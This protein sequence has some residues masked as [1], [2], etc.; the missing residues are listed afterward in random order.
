MAVKKDLIINTIQC[1]TLAETTSFWNEIA[2]KAEGEY[3]AILQDGGTV[4]VSTP[5]D[6]EIGKVNAA[7][8][9]TV[10]GYGDR[11]MQNVVQEKLMRAAEAPAE[12]LAERADF[13]QKTKS[14]PSASAK[15]VSG[16]ADLTE[17]AADGTLKYDKLERANLPE[18]LKSLSPEQQKAEV[19]KNVAERKRLNA[20]METLVKKRTDFLKG[21]KARKATTDK[22]DGFDGQVKAMIK[23]QAAGKGIRY[24]T[25]D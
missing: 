14:V 1:G 9:K 17:L 24:S 21:E 16:I 15:V 5:F 12:A 25:D 22:G 7:L 23:K 20:E 3:A 10:L 6:A 18:P 11:M 2:D 8:S 19:E 13:L 4:A